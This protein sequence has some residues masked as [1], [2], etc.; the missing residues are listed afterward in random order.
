MESVLG[1]VYLEDSPR[2]MYKVIPIPGIERGLAA[3]TN[4]PR[5]Y[6]IQVETRILV[7]ERIPPPSP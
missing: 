2:T 5:G 7:A 3:E 6:R 1:A 4:I